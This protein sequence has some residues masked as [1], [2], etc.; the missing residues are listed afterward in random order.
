MPAAQPQQQACRPNPVCLTAHWSRALPAAGC[1][2]FTSNGWLKAFIKPQLDPFPDYAWICQGLFIA[3][4]VL[5]T[6]A[7]WRAGV[8]PESCLQARRVAAAA[9]R[10][11]AAMPPPSDRLPCLFEL[12][13]AVR[14]TPLCENLSS[15]RFCAHC[16]AGGGGQSQL[17]VA[18]GG[19]PC[20]ATINVSW[21]RRL[22]YHSTAC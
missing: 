14:P 15:Q 7:A 16:A 8:A 9:Q 13:A 4:G 17:C 6:P 20:L 11:R 10:S 21:G 12:P 3:N 5:H 2:G 18:G 1:V 22:A 19:V